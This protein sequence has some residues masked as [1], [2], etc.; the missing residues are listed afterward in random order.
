MIK[1][2]ENPL[3][4]KSENMLAVVQRFEKSFNYIKP[5]V[6]GEPLVAS[7]SSQPRTSSLNPNVTRLTTTSSRSTTTA[8]TREVVNI[9]HNRAP[10]PIDYMPGALSGVGDL[11]CDTRVYLPNVVFKE[12]ETKIT[13]SK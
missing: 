5:K 1:T 8:S 7:T 4:G 3:L 6:S 13:P 2:K 11:T 9:G 10:E 12:N